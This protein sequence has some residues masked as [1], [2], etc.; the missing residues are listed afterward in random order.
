MDPHLPRPKVM[1]K[2]IIGRFMRVALSL[3]SVLLGILATGCQPIPK[4]SSD[5]TAAEAL[6]PNLAGG[7][8]NELNFG[9]QPSQAVG[10]TDVP[11]THLPAASAQDRDAA[12]SAP[13]YRIRPN[14]PLVIYLRGIVP[15]DEEFQLIVNER[16][17]ITLPFIGSV[18]AAGKTASEL[19][20]EIQRTYIERDIYR[21]ITVNVIVPSQSFFVQGEVRVPQRYPMVTGM[22]LMQAIAAAGGYTEYADRR[23]VTLTRG[24]VVRTINMRDIE[25]DPRLDITIESGDVIRVP[26]SIF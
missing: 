13:A 2:K 12:S 3:A 26:R 22:T 15:R 25:R 1:H 23:R 6:S 19:E 5:L 17:E 7:A 24:G 21:T 16:G 8:P 20:R 4:V 10:Q 11:S 9:A 14:D 18:E